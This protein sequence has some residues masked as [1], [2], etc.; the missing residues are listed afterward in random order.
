MSKTSLLRRGGT[1]RPLAVL[2]AL[3]FIQCDSHPTALEPPV[4]D[5]G[6]LTVEI[7][8]SV[9]EVQWQAN[10]PEEWPIRFTPSMSWNVSF[11]APVSAGGLDVRVRLLDE[12]GRSC[13]ESG[14]SI[15]E[16]SQ[17]LPYVAG[18]ST[19][20]FPVGSDWSQGRCGND[21][22]AREIEAVV[23]NQYLPGSTKRLQD[24]LTRRIPCDLRFTRT[25]RRGS[26]P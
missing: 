8:P 11:V 10:P 15:G 5:N 18:G 23:S 9:A 17:G 6:T 24:L 20:T 4:A 22:A 7:T 1:A 21:F 26:R 25:G 14:A 2:A 3:V 16:V 12:V 19:F 13:F